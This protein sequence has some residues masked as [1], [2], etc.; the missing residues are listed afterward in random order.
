MEKYIL[1]T[2]GRGPQECNLA[3]QLL[4]EKL[5]AAASAQALKLEIVK[6]EKV[7]G[8]P[9]SALLKLTGR[10]AVRFADHWIGAICWICQSPFRPNHKRKNWF[11]EVKGWHPTADSVQLKLEDV[12]F[13]AM[14]SSGAGGQ[15]VN[16]V[17]S[18]VRAIHL[19]TGLTVQVMD[20]RSQLQNKEIAILRLEERLK[21]L[22]QVEKDA[23]KNWEWKNQIDVKRGGAKRIFIGSKFKEQGT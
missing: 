9:S 19:P 12:K 15:H 8:L 11:V 16:K 3:V 14:R 22:E 20:T 10:G 13:Q 18:A 4:L 2:S 1:I 5:E 7:E 21:E 6:V 17:S 23:M